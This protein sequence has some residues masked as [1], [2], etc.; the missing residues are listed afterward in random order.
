MI[1]SEGLSSLSLVELKNACAARGNGGWKGRGKREEGRG[2]REEGIEWGFC[3]GVFFFE[4][5]F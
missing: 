2:K 5:F 3:F 1:R 4:C